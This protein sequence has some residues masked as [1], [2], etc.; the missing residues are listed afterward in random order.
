V[1]AQQT[2]T[3][4]TNVDRAATVLNE[5]ER[6][7][8]IF[9]LSSLIESDHQHLTARHYPVDGKLR[10][11]NDIRRMELA[12]FRLGGSDERYWPACYR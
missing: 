9:A 5:A 10:R 8:A 4:K 12:Y 3:W 2:A 11:A 6:H 7:A 1:S